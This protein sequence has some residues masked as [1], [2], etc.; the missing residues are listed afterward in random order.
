MSTSNG[1][2]RTEEGYT[3]GPTAGEQDATA[4]RPRSRAVGLT[5]LVVVVL[6]V[7]VLSI[8]WLAAGGEEGH[9]ETIPTAPVK[10]GGLTVSVTEGGTLQAMESMKVKS[11]VEGRSTI[12]EIIPEG[13]IITEE[14]VENGKVLVKLDAT[15]LEEKKDQ[16]EMSYRNAEASYIQAKE[17][18]DIQL[19][20]NRSNI[21]KAELDLK[22]KEMELERYLGDRLADLFL[23]GE[24]SFTDIGPLAR[25]EVRQILA[26]DAELARELLGEPG[27]SESGSSTLGLGG[28]A[29]QKLRE[30]ASNLQLA[31][32]EL[33][34]AEDDLVWTEKLAERD[35]VSDNE[36]TADRL[37]QQRAAVR[38]DSAKEELRLFM[39][40]TLPKEV[41]QRRS[42]YEEAE[43][44]LEK[45]KAK[46]R[47]EKAQ[48][49]AN[50]ESKKHN[51]ELDKERLD[52]TKEMIEN[53]TIAAT[54]PGLVVYASTTNPWGRRNNPI[55]EGAEIRHNE[56]LITMPDLNTLAARV[57]VHETQI[58]KVKKDQPARISVEALGGEEFPGTVAKISPMASSEHRWLNP[59][60]MVY[61]TDVALEEFPEDVTPGMSATAEIVVAELEDVLYI[62][63]QAVTTHRG[64]RVCW[65]KTD[66][67]PQLRR[68]EC[69]HFTEKFVQVKEGLREGE[70]VYLAPPEELE[71]GLGEEEEAEEETRE[72]SPEPAERP[73]DQQEGQPEAAEAEEHEQDVPEEVRKL[74]TKLEDMSDEEKREFF[75]NM[76]EQQRNKLFQ[77]ARDLSGEQRRKLLQQFGGMG[78]GRGGGP[79][80]G[81]G[82][83]RGRQGQ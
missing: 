61:E 32:K 6:L 37:E 25:R 24:M 67:P 71:E 11:K 2:T 55:Q 34:R 65:V 50:K 46:A 52:K 21:N 22:F 15:E 36:L 49:E 26:Q 30:L 41:E 43:L 73:A 54:K 72:P 12:L 47:S 19:K 3:A 64:N 53:S 4:R 56:T 60:V 83:G 8:R 17:N 82:G 38:L 7:A 63:V 42:D 5:V 58:S 39:R 27:A 28:E 74:L 40:Y 62:P 45:V 44:E 18:Y 29:R 59:D 10:R 51:L 31:K 33:T 66:G 48:A 35:F 20:Q 77:Q 81:R 70:E 80:G 23:A 1:E 75:R 16:Q 14:D 68:I 78:G 76:S 79:G 57:N 69:G 13:T 9:Y